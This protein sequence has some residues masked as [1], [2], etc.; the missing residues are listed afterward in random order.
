MTAIA[1][2]RL[3]AQMGIADTPARKDLTTP[4]DDLL[5]RFAEARAEDETSQLKALEAVGSHVFYLLRTRLKHGVDMLLRGRSHLDPV[6]I[7]I[8]T[9]KMAGYILIML[10]DGPGVPMISRNIKYNKEAVVHRDGCF[11]LSAVTLQEAFK[12]VDAHMKVADKSG[13]LFALG[14]DYAE[15]A[16][17]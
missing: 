1:A 8:E 6:C 5:Y 14:V 16:V 13:K 7:S 15:L 11:E 2:L 4:L 17:D 10:H 12:W 3:K 9:P